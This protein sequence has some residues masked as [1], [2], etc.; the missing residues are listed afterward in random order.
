MALAPSFKGVQGELFRNTLATT[1]PIAC[2][3]KVKGRG[4]DGQMRRSNNW[5]EEEKREAHPYSVSCHAFAGGNA[6]R[7]AIVSW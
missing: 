3:R 1:L 7:P 5:K 6:V 2:N 4:Q